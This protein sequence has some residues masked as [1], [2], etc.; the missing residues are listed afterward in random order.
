MNAISPNI[1]DNLTQRGL[2]RLLILFLGLLFVFPAPVLSAPEAIQACGMAQVVDDN[3]GRA[4]T[5]ALADAQRNAV[6]MGIGTLIDAD[7]IVNNAVLIKDRIYSRTTGYVTNY[8]ITSEG[9]TPSGKAYE[10]CIEATVDT[11]DIKADLRA[12]GILKQRVGNPRFMVVYLPDS[13]A[14]AKDHDL[15]VKE[16]QRVID[17]VFI[18]KGFIV[19]NRSLVKEFVRKMGQ[20]RIDRT[21]VAGM[22]KIAST[23]QAD[24]LMLFNVDA[25]ERTEL[26]NAY[27]KEIVLSLTVQCVSPG[28]AEI[29]SSN[30][31]TTKI[32]TSKSMNDNYYASPRIAKSMSTLAEQVAEDTM[33]DTL[34][35][36]DRQTHE[37]TLYICRFKGFGQDEIRTIVNVIENLGGYRDKNVR[38]QFSDAVQLDVNYMGKKFEFQR[39][40]LS[41]LEKEGIAV[42]IGSIEGNNF[43][44]LGKE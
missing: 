17:D 34:A 33:A 30:G 19:L 28:T 40:L 9:L 43:L 13:G 31:R 6:E 21:D 23:Y 5:Q 15:V 25:S 20:M 37:G 39:E 32:R 38:N 8:H 27:F 2:G 44:I 35:F 7:T 22:S 4:K 36:L 3:V 41:G 42:T 26:S 10:T 16:A 24:L 14:A 12:I 11:A 1:V 29:I 18:K